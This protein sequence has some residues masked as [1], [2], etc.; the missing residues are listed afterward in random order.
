VSVIAPNAALAD[1]LATALMVM[2]FEKG[3]A[4]VQRLRNI[5]ALWITKDLEQ[6]HSAGFWI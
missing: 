5:E 6:I 2:D 3:Y 4:L 1:A